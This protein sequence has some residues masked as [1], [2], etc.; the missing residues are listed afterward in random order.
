[1]SAQHTLD[2]AQALYETPEAASATRAPT[3]GGSLDASPRR[4]PR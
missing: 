4:C 3:A 1:M 2:V